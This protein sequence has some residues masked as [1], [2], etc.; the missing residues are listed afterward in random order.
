MAGPKNI[1]HNNDLIISYTDFR[2]SHNSCIMKYCCLVVLLLVCSVVRLS[3]GSFVWL[4]DCLVVQLS[5]CL[6]VQLSGFPVVWL[7]SC[8]TVWLKVLER[9]SNKKTTFHVSSPSFLSSSQPLARRNSDLVPQC[10][11][12]FSRWFPLQNIWDFHVADR[13]GCSCA[14]W[15]LSG[16]R[17]YATKP[18]ET[19]QHSWCRAHHCPCPSWRK[20]VHCDTKPRSPRGWRQLCHIR[21]YWACTEDLV[22][23][24]TYGRWRHT[25]YSGSLPTPPE[26]PRCLILSGW[27]QS[28]SQAKTLWNIHIQENMCHVNTLPFSGSPKPCS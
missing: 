15:G 28:A 10:C 14:R 16:D 7:S 13:H 2:I 9:Y 6:V 23:L 26:A 11:P 3:I 17:S 4:S 22:L 21:R 19:V 18:H 27:T 24:W 1:Q 12:H 25:T 8:L 20:L 5:N